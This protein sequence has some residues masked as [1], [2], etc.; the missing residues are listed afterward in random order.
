MESILNHQRLRVFKLAAKL[1]ADNINVYNAS[2]WTDEIKIQMH[3][4]DQV[5]N[6]LIRKGFKDVSDPDDDFIYLK[7]CFLKFVI[8]T[9]QPIELL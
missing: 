3:Y 9:D 4:D 7:K 2:F 8:D 6:T 1:L 5:V